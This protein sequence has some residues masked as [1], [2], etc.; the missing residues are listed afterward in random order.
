M[1]QEARLFKLM[2]KQLLQLHSLP[3]SIQ[4]PF[5]ITSPDTGT[6]NCIAWALERTDRNYWVQPEE[7]FYWPP[8]LPRI[9]SLDAFILLFELAGYVNCDTGELEPGFQKIALFVKNGLPTHAARQLP[10]GQWTSK[11]GILEDVR[12]SLQSISGGLYGEA[13]V[14]MKRTMEADKTA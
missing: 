6:Y 8:G 9:E 10:E 4:E 14:F 1:G 5:E 7:F 12:H 13:A 11:L 3:N 2:K